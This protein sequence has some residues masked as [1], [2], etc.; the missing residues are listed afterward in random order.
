MSKWLIHTVGPVLA[1][2]LIVSTVTGAQDARLIKL[3]PPQMERGK[4]LMQA[5][6]ERKT[7]RA[8]SAE[9][10]PLQEL[11][12]LLWAAYGVNR[13]ESGR[14]T[15]PSAMNWQE[16]DIYVTTA[17][18]LFRYDAKAHALEV[19][20]TKDIRAMTGRQPFVPNVPVNLVYV[21]DFSR[22]GRAKAEDKVFYSAADAGFISQNVYLYCASEGLV[23][24]VRGLV[25][26]TSLAKVMQLRP[27]QRVLLS[28]SLGYPEK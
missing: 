3:L 25:D 13:P 14:R 24:V 28:Q 7:S 23:T 20:S 15:A 9:P 27:E 26:K 2:L 17:D 19:I 22:M 4:P 12:N 21:A 5:L 18:G 11:S 10:L 1:L 8:F 16:I 6:K